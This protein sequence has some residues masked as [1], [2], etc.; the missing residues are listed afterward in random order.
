MK[1]RL[2]IFWGKSGENLGK[3]WGKSGENLGKIWGKSGESLPIYLINSC[4]YE[5]LFL[6]INLNILEINLNILEMNVNMFLINK[7][8]KN[9]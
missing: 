3:I 1:I 4:F 5:L 2:F 8:A 6:E 7:S 9:V